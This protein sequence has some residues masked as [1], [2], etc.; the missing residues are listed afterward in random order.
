MLTVLQ[1]QAGDIILRENEVGETAY[2]IE[3]GRVEITRESPGH[4]MHLAYRGAGDIFGEM[5]MIDDKPRSATVTAV[6]KTVVREIHRESFFD[7][8]QANS[9]LALT[10]LRILFERLREASVSIISLRLQLAA[11]QPSQA[12]A[13]PS[14]RVSSESGTM[15]RLTGETPRAAQSLPPIPVVTTKFP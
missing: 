11:F 7:D 9:E 13:M 1:F 15:L 3:Q 8:F 10:F 6:Q 12:P 14:F 2:F 5:S 4:K